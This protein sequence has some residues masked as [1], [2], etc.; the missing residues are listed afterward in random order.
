M[1]TAPVALAFLDDPGSLV[2][3]ATAISALTHHDPEAGEACALWCLAIR[4]AVLRGTFDG[5]REALAYLPEQRAAV[6]AQRLDESESSEPADFEHNG[7]VVEAWQGAWSAITNAQAPAATASGRFP[8]DHLRRA[9]ETAV[10]GGRDTDTVAAIAGSLLGAKWGASAVPS[11][12]RRLVHGWPGL[13]ARD[14]VRLGVL[15]ARNGGSDPQGWP[16]GARVD[17]SSYPH[18]N[19]IAAHPYDDRVW[20]SGVEALAELPEGVDAVVSL[21]RLG[22]DDVPGVA[23]KADSHVE[24]WLIDDANPAKNP[25]LDYVLQD[26]ASAVAAFRAEDK[27]VLLHCVQAQSRT[28]TVAAL[29][30]AMV[31]GRPP[32]DCLADVLKALPAAHPNSAMLAALE[33]LS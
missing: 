32:M 5:L 3:A 19:A 14:L 21:C 12:W 22:I 29:Y 2:E 13:R 10:R 6:W 20:L 4:H 25:H 11:A 31:T 30:G 7:W 27:T 28:P 23:V 9:L 33:R 15:S 8:A 16:A 18:R 17:Y 24:V 26:A 1:R